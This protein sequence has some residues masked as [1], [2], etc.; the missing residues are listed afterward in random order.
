MKDIKATA[1]I[2]RV[3]T[4]DGSYMSIT[5]V[6]DFS[7][8]TL[9][10]LK[11]TLEEFTRLLTGESFS[12]IDAELGDVETLGK[13]REQETFEFKVCDGSAYTGLKDL[14]IAEGLKVC[15]K[16]WRLSTYFGS[17]SSFFSKDGDT[18]ARTSI[19]KYKEV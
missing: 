13:V 3:Q 5:I 2:A 6:D 14:A 15:P 12:D 7:H 17:Q 9:C 11:L 1:T 16:G 4:Y 8:G 19:Y 18:W 10:R